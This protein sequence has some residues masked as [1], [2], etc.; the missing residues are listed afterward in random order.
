MLS[1]HAPPA[2]SHAVKTSAAFPPNHQ[3]RDEAPT[4]YSLVSFPITLSGSD[5]F[6][7][8][9]QQRFSEDEEEE[10]GREQVTF[11]SHPQRSE[12]HLGSGYC[13]SEE[14]KIYAN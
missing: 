7:L 4:A 2:Q 6:S 12:R 8:S 11:L 3:H 13:S 5:F 1:P 10:G 9:R 14:R